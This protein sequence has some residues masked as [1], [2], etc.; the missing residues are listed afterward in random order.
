MTWKTQVRL[1]LQSTEGRIELVSCNLD[2]L[3]IFKNL[4]KG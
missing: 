3:S 2:M 4:S 1:E